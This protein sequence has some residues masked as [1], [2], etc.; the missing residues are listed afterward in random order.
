[1]HLSP[2]LS[3]IFLCIYGVE[4]SQF[5][6]ITDTLIDITHISRHFAISLLLVLILLSTL[7]GV[8]TLANICSSLMPLFLISYIFLT[9]YIII[10]HSH[11]I[12]SIFHMIIQDA[13]S[14]GAIIGGISGA[15]IVRAMHYGTARAVYSGDIGIGYDSIIQSETRIKDPQIQARLAIISLFTDTL[16]CTLSCLVIIVTGVWKID[17]PMSNYIK[18]ALSFYITNDLL[19]NSYI[20]FIFFIAGFTTLIGYFVVGQK[21]AFFLNK[22]YGKKLYIIYAIFSFVFFSFYGQN[23]VMLIMS[24]SGGILMLINIIGIFKLRKEIKFE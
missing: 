24:V 12:G 11:E 21:C 3:A 1:M 16:I 5:L 6:V 13:F 23:E 9:F 4:V 17:M 15:G 18:K 7:G 14:G 19:L 22:K 8:R 20:L 10:D 2:I